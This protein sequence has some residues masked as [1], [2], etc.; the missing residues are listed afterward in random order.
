MNRIQTERW[1]DAALFENFYRRL[2][3]IFQHTG[4]PLRFRDAEGT[5]DLRAATENRILDDRCRFNFAVEDDSELPANVGTGDASENRRAFFV[6]TQR[7]VRPSDVVVG[8]VSAFDVFA[9]ETLFRFKFAEVILGHCP[10][11]RAF[12][13]LRQVRVTERRMEIWAARFGLEPVIVSVNEK[14][15]KV[16]G[17]FNGP[18][19]FGA[20][21]FTQSR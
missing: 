13:A 3:W 7:N 14:E 16:S 21:I 11:F 18:A 15:F 5:G 8:D 19:G 2:Q 9:G 17:L 20:D 1:I 10:A 12:H 6:E 4:Q